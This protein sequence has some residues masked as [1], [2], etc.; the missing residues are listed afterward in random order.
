MI[1][2]RSLSASEIAGLYANQ[3]SKYLT[4]SI[5]M[6]DGQKNLT[7]YSQDSYANVGSSSVLFNVDSSGPTINFV[8][9]SPLSGISNSNI[10][11]NATVSDSSGQTLAMFTNGL[12]SWWRMDDLNSTNGLVDYMGRN[13]G[14]LV[15]NT[16]QIENGKFGKRNEF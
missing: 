6:I 14:T 11:L 3:S 9:P 8:E 5:S 7:I 1:F 4:T 16:A 15:G 2:N 12:V 10:T 13:N